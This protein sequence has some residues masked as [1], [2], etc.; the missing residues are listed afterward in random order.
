MAE[1]QTRI[2]LVTHD[3]GDATFR[4]GF[5]AA[6]ND[7]TLDIAILGRE[8]TNLFAVI[9]DHPGNTVCLLRDNDRYQIIRGGSCTLNDSGSSIVA[10]C[11]ISSALTV[12][13]DG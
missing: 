1:V 5:A 12:L 11:R 9:V 8:I 4:G 7:E 3:G 2:R 10:A 13:I 6:I